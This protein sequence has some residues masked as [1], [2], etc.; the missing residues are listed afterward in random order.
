MQHLGGPDAYYPGAEGMQCLGGP[1]TRY[2]VMPVEQR[3][4]GNLC[5]MGFQPCECQ[6]MAKPVGILSRYLLA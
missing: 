2:R 6:V 1:D 5:E 4:A 3:D